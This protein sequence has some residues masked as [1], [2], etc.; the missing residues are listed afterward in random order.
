M[1]LCGDKYKSYRHHHIICAVIKR[2]DCLACVTEGAAL[3]AVA[4]FRTN[5]A[6]FEDGQYVQFYLYVR[7]QDVFAGELGNDT[8]KS[9]ESRYKQLVC[10]GRKQSNASREHLLYCINCHVNTIGPA[11]CRLNVLTP[12]LLWSPSMNTKAIRLTVSHQACMSPVVEPLATQLCCC[13]DW[14]T[15]WE[16]TPCRG[17]HV[18]G[19]WPKPQLQWRFRMTASAPHVLHEPGP[20]VLLPVPSVTCRAASQIR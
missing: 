20:S 14:S 6:P 19:F 13:V 18:A 10:P 15:I 4:R 5:T 7:I 9:G 17:G 1:T 3:P 16:H 12:S 8:N 11:S 2:A